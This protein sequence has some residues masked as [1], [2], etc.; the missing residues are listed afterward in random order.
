MVD[1]THCSQCSALL[2]EIDF[3]GERMV[4]CI[5]CYRWTRD[6]W[7]YIHWAEEDLAAL[8]ADRG[9]KTIA[10]FL[11]LQT[12]WTMLRDD[13]WYAYYNEEKPLGPFATEAEAV[14]AGLRAWRKETA[15]GGSSWGPPPRSRLRVTVVSAFRPGIKRPPR[16]KTSSTKVAW[17]L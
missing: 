16:R 8:R 4:A 15:P 11:E 7:L 17:W 6:G 12:G 9:P 10:E 13:G 14:R 1:S 5:D 2:T 3:Y